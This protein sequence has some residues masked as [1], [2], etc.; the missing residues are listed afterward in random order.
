MNLRDITIQEINDAILETE[1]AVSEYDKELKTK[2]QV[3]NGKF[4]SG[5]LKALGDQMQALRKL[6]GMKINR[7]VAM[8][9][10]RGS[11]VITRW[12][13]CTPPQIVCLCGSTKFKN[14]F[15]RVNE[16]M[17]LDG[18]IV[19]SVGKFDQVKG[20]ARDV[21]KESLDELH[22]RKIDLCDHVYVI[23]VDGYISESTK[24]EI[25]YAMTL[26]KPVLYLVEPP[27]VSKC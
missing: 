11:G 25:E 9:M 2:E 5:R 6:R 19:L 16:E 12:N 7:L 13:V 14:Q 24:S 20:T 10:P 17:T 8:S 27:C 21:T 4:R 22:K 26:E 3:D 15:E 18:M 23:N 1:Y